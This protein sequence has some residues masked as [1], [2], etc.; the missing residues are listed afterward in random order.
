MLLDKGFDHST[1]NY[2][3][4]INDEVTNTIAYHKTRKLNIEALKQATGGKVELVSNDRTRK[5]QKPKS[6]FLPKPLTS[7]PFFAQPEAP[8][9]YLGNTHPI[10]KAQY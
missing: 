6:A 10:M 3:Y 5:R 7:L 1:F 2:T 8:F 4:S 9:C